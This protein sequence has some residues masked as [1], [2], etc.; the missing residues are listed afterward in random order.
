MSSSP[1]HA[2]SSS[3]NVYCSGG[4]CASAR[5]SGQAGFTIFALEIQEVDSDFERL[6]DIP[7]CLKED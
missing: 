1:T 6:S 3:V 2:N 4:A 5:P 7:I